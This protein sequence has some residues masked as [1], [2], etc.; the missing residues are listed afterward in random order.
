MRDAISVRCTRTQDAGG[1]VII[2]I[3]KATV[4]LSR[5]QFIA[6]LKRGKAWKRHETLARRDATEARGR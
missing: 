2:E 5:E 4:V 1:W 3:P 6:A